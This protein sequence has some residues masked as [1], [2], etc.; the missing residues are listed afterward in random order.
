MG[1]FGMR[2]DAWVMVADGPEGFGEG[3]RFLGLHGMRKNSYL[4]GEPAL[5]RAVTA[6]R[7]RYRDMDLDNYFDEVY[8]KW[9][10]RMVRFAGTYFGN[11]EEAE[12]AVQDVFLK[13]YQTRGLL[14]PK[15]NM[16]AWLFTV[17]KN[18]C[19]DELRKIDLS[20]LQ[21]LDQREIELRLQAL[22]IFDEEDMSPQD[23]ED[24]VR[25]AVES[26]PERCRKIFTM[27]RIQGLKHKRIAEELGISTSTVE[28]QMTIAY[29]K[30]RASLEHYM[31]LFVFFFG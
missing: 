10:P 19:I 31:P 5:P 27:S 22:E 24:K 2:S 11:R 6:N 17:V 16:E 4:Y 14:P 13:I 23:I 21:Y 30:L 20:K 25:G 29:K 12:N 28:N 9:F 26:L 7:H 8:V 15:V 18:K 3:L 1:G